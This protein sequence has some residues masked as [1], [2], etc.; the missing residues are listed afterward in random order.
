MIN[1]QSPADTAMRLRVHVRGQVQGVGF[2]PFIYRLAAGMSLSGW[3]R[4]VGAGVEIEIEGAHVDID[5][6][7][8]RL[9]SEAPR[10]AR[11]EHLSS[12]AIDPEGSGEPF[13]IILSTDDATSTSI[14]PDSALCDDC[15]AEICDPANRRY[16][17][18]FTH[19]IQCGP[20][21]TITARL[22]Y[23]RANT[24]MAAFEEC[25]A[26]REER[27]LPNERRFHA[28]TNACRDCGPRLWLADSSGKEPHEGDVIAAALAR[29]LRGEILAIKGLGGY[30]LVCDARNADAVRMLR[31]RKAREE[32][33]FAIMLASLVSLDEFVT[34]NEEDAALLNSPQR[35]IVLLPKRAGCDDKLA[36]IAPGLASLGVMLPCTPIQ[37]LL[38]HEAAGRPDGSNWLESPQP[39]ALVM[40][41]ANPHGEPLVTGNEQALEQLAD[42]ADAFLMHDRDILIRCDDSVIR[43]TAAG[44]APQFVRRA[45]GYVPTPIALGIEGAPGLAVGPY[46]NNTICVARAGEAF[47]SQHIGDL[48]T[49]A[50]CES[51]DATVAHLLDILQVEPQWVAADLHEDFYSTRFARAF[52]AE[53]GLPVIEVQHHHAHI[54]AVMAE[55]RL[56]GPVLGVALDGFGLGSDGAAWGGEL[57]L[58]DGASSQR[59]G[60]LLPLRL[61]GGDRAAR[62]PWRMAAAAL[63]D[64]G[65]HGEIVGRFGAQAA[66]I[67]TM[68]EKGLNTPATSSAGRLFDAA[69]GLLGIKPVTSFEGQAATML[70]GLAT[71]YGPV[72]PMPHGYS[73]DG[74]TLNMLPLLGRLA[75][76]RD[77]GHAAALFHATVVAALSDWIQRAVAAH[78]VGTIAFG[79][80]CFLNR[81]LSNTLRAKLEAQG[82]RVIES[83]LVPPGDGGVSLGQ[84]W[85]ALHSARA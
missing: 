33:P 16:R 43:P 78:G 39:L 24:S 54:G 70:E 73:V 22:P 61:P 68:L 15:I 81:I 63:F 2:R 38:F 18:P 60:H 7:V 53:R 64:L 29:L 12:A 10:A 32:K 25:P 71:A 55:H 14:A 56:S 59:V 3:V 47:V 82:I 41:S 77:V 21:Y 8:H 79:G 17:H 35:P 30:H 45:R 23:D 27:E 75:D 62:E 83:A 52:A 80:G 9:R 84:A 20:R 31:E 69:A 85:V 4:N 44:R 36:G 74:M 76:I 57:L 19:C 28:Q 72:D 67:G 48:D 51:F 58:V 65:R 13:R 66:M 50:T 6:F 46:L 5:A 26:C 11:I 49:R 40:T 37:Y 34:C 42:I 1:E